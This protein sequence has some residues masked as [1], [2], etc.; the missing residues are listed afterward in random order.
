MMLQICMMLQIWKMPALAPN[1]AML[2][3]AD[4]TRVA[5]VVG[6]AWRGCCSFA[7]ERL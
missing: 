7:V 6:I 4:D 1:Y 2:R 5:C 3:A